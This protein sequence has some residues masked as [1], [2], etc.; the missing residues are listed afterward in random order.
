MPE[1]K[2]LIRK[3]ASFKGKVTVFVNYLNTL[4]PDSLSPTEVSELQFR[5]IKLE[6]LYAQYDEVQ[7][8]LECTTDNLDSQLV[9]RTLFQI[10]N[11][12][13]ESAVNLKA[14]LDTINKNLRALESL[15][16][17][18][19]HWDTLLIYI[20][21]NK[22]DSK[23]YREW[24]EYKG[25]LSRDSKITFKLFIT[26]IKNRA[27]ILETLELSTSNKHSNPGK[28]SKHVRTMLAQDSIKSN[29]YDNHKQDNGSSNKPKNCVMCN[30]DHKLSSC[31]QFL[32]LNNESRL[33][34]L[35]KY[36]VC[37]NCFNH[38][39]YAN[40]CKRFGCKI[41]R[42]KHN[43]LVH[44]DIVSKLSK[45]DQTGASS[46]S[47][48][49]NDSV[50]VSTQSAVGTGLSLSASVAQGDVLLA[51]AL[52]KIMGI[53]GKQYVV[54]AVLDSGSTSCLMTERL[55]HQLDC[56]EKLNLSID[57]Q[58]TKFWQLEEV[59]TSSPYSLEEK[60]CEEHFIKNTV[61]L[62]NGQFC[63][64]IPLKGSP[65]QLA[66]IIQYPRLIQ[67]Q[68]S[69][70]VEDQQENSP[71]TQEIYVQL[72]GRLRPAYTYL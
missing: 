2:E 16:E 24:E 28:H 52:V 46:S 13:K 3:R 55:F 4:E 30:G 6:A 69:N 68:Q 72:I 56:D 43:T 57:Q 8:L 22:F 18:V 70:K 9:E 66:P 35:P 63:V 54:R 17:P 38:G 45:S 29:T 71:T 60:L 67:E 44:V 40:S 37:Y 42:R 36:K 39:H 59:Y 19:S 11:L 1:D 58:L 23:T 14:L 51:T 48:N 64:R 27:E 32:S 20:I 62:E 15:G 5:F 12:Q 31:T 25:C 10:D 26:F 33:K 47:D 21:T 65:D 41:C 34:L 50:N 49:T 61:R 53:N 7:L